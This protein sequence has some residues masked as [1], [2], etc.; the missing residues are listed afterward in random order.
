M[1]WIVRALALA[2]GDSVSALRAFADA[3]L[4]R[5]AYDA[6][7]PATRNYVLSQLFELRTFLPSATVKVIPDAGHHVVANSASVYGAIRFI[8]G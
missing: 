3:T 2:R 6:S 4:G 7:P 5:G 8:V 1:V